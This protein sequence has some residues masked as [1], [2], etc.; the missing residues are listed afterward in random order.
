MN[1][2]PYIKYNKEDWEYIKKNLE[3]FGY[4]K[5]NLSNNWELSPYIVINFADDFGC[6]SNVMF[7]DRN[8]YGREEVT[9][10]EEFLE[11]AANL[12]GLIYIRRDIVKIHDVEI[13]PGIGIYVDDKYN[14]NNL[15]IVFPTKDGLGLI[16]YGLSCHWLHLDQFLSEYKNRIVAIYDLANEHS[17]TGKILWEAPKKV[18]ITMEEIAKKFGV[19]VEQIQIE[20]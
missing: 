1:G 15:Y 10:V 8:N 7:L 19:S 17:I 11:R 9:N 6:Y 16:N 2:I 20:K 12:K 5:T 18:I 13:K 14:N 4:V 3:S